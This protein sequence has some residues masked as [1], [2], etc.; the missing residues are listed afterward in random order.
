MAR[1]FYLCIIAVAITVLAVAALPSPKQTTSMRLVKL[2]SK[3]HG[4]SDSNSRKFGVDGLFRPRPILAKSLAQFSGTPIINLPM[5]GN[6][7]PI[8]RSPS[9]SRPHTSNMIN[10]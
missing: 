3:Q 8:V 10:G 4:F 5:G 7:W 9:I 6:I 1:Q 2:N